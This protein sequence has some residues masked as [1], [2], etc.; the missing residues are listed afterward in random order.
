L[1]IELTGIFITIA[2][3][4]QGKE[5]KKG[6]RDMEFNDFMRDYLTNKPIVPAAFEQTFNGQH[7]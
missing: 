2:K 3:E 6:R 5:K 4:N 7:I 1:R